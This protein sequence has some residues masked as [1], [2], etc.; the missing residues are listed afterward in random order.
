M[1]KI[2]IVIPTYD[3]I[4]NIELLISEVENILTTE[5]SNYDYE[6]IIIDNHSKDGTREKIKELC[7]KNKNIKGILNAKNFGQLDRKSVV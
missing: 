5:L 7:S 2:S 4:E 3:E 1:K 6:I